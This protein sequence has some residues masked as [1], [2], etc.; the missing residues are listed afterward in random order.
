[1]AK[2]VSRDDPR[3]LYKQVKDRLLA[4]MADGTLPPRSKIASERELVT[5]FGVSRITI[6]QAM[7]ELVQEGQLRS[8][9]GKG[10]YA[11]GRRHTPAYELELLRSFT[12]TALDHGSRPGSRLLHLGV[13][14]ATPE[15]ALPL[16]IE[17]GAEVVSLRRLRLLDDVPVAISHDWIAL[18]HVPDIASLDWEA[19]NRSLYAELRSRYGLMPLRGQTILSARL[20]RGDEAKLLDLPAAAAVLTV[21]QI[22]YDAHNTPINL[23]F[24]TH[25]PERY[26]LQLEQEGLSR[27]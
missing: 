4:A 26:P 22:A 8:H 7:K 24:S 5:T 17:D 20:A 15:I 16:L 27:G 21:E 10:F 13:E 3:P 14:P 9:P 18:A 1:M 19:Q 6:R 12:A 2:G 11:T 23:T 25:H